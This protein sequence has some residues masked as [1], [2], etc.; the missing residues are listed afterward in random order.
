MWALWGGYSPAGLVF[1]NDLRN[2]C[3]IPVTRHFNEQL[4]KLALELLAAKTVAGV[5]SRVTDRPMPVVT[6]MVGQFGIQCPLDQLFGQLF[7]DAVRT[8][9]VFRLLVV[10]KKLIQQLIS[11]GV[12]LCHGVS[13]S[14][15]QC[16]SLSG[17]TKSR[18]PSQVLIQIISKIYIAQ[19]GIKFSI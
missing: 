8:D 17:Y 6:Q 9:Q 5:A 15:R 2:E 12:F 13:G 7:E 19:Y 14:M 11:N 3:A 4:T 1:L 18:T 10:S 16:R